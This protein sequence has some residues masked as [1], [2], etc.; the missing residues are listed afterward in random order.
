MIT[1]GAGCHRIDPSTRPVFGWNPASR[2]RAPETPADDGNRAAWSSARSDPASPV[3]VPA[4]TVRQRGSAGVGRRRGGGLRLRLGCRSRVGEG[5][6][7]QRPRLTGVGDADVHL[8]RLRGRRHDERD[9]R[10]VDHLRIVED[11]VADTDDG[12]GPE[13]AAR[14]RDLRAA[15]DRSLGR[16]DGSD[17]RRRHVGEGIVEERDGQSGIAHPD[18]HRAEASG[19]RHGR[20]AGAA[21]DG[22]PARGILPE[23]DG[24]PVREARARDRDLRAAG[25]GTPRRAHGGHHPGGLVDVPEPVLERVGLAAGVADVHAD[26]A[27]RPRGGD[28]PQGRVVQHLDIRRRTAEEGHHHALDEV[29]ALD[30]DRPRHRRW[31][32]VSGLRAVMRS[33]GGAT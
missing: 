6:L 25:L 10:L 15:V 3:I 9:R 27:G 32:P 22:D 2:S 4:E 18:G 13:A 30:D 21:L 11:D 33:T 16:L 20:D 8:D 31:S 28:D 23:G 29:D 14:D 26:P 7:G 5:P 24:R 19:R 12:V 1:G 17:H